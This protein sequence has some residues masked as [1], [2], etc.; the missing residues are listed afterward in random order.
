M[1]ERDP[2]PAGRF[3]VRQAGAVDPAPG[4]L[5]TDLSAMAADGELM[6]MARRPFK[7]R[8]LFSN[9]YLENQLKA[10]PEWARSDHE[11]AFGDIRRIYER[12]SAFVGGLSEAQLEER[13]IRRVFAVILPEYEV[14]GATRSR[15]FPDYAFFPHREARDRA[16]AKKDTESFFLEAF[17][18][19]EVKRWDAELDRFGRDRQDKRRNPSFQIWLYLTE[20]EPAWGILS[21][22]GRWRLYR[23]DRPL[24]VYYE[25][26]L[27][28]ILEA[29]DVD[30]FRYFYYFF[31]QEAFLP[32]QRG[33]VFLE[34][35]LRG[36]A[37]Y[38]REIGENLKENVYR[39]GKVLADGFIRWPENRLDPADPETRGRVQRSTMILLYRFLFLLYAEGKE[40]LDLRDERYASSYSFDRIKKEVAL[41]RDGPAA[42]GFLPIKRSLWSDLSDLFRLIDRGSERLGIGEL[43]EVPAYN[44]GLFDP[45]RH[46]DL[47]EWTIGDSYLAEAI[48]LLSR[49]EAGSG[50]GT[51]TGSG[52]G[53]GGGGGKKGEDGGA[54]G[55][56]SGA[57]GGGKGFVDYSTLEI[58]HLGS[59]Y[60]GLLEY[61]LAVADEDLVVS[62]GKDRRWVSLAEYNQGKKKER[63]FQEF[64]EF[65]RARAGEL[66]LTTDRGERKATG[67]YY[68]P[69]YIVDYIVEKTV[70]P[71]VEGRWKEALLEEQSLIEATLAVKVLDP[72]MGSGHFLVGAVEFLAGKLLRA[73]ERDIDWGWVED[74]GQFTPEW[75]KRE[76]V[77]RCIYGVDLNELAV[78]LA[79]VSLWLSTIAK[80]KPLSFLDHRLKQG[81]SLVG[82]RLSDLMNYPGSVGADKDQTTLPSFVSPRFLTHLIGK[83]REL[84]EIGDD[85]LSEIKEK[86]RVFEEFRSL[87]EYTK[88][89]AIANV[90]T[91]V[92]FGGG[93]EARATPQGTKDP[94]QVYHDLFWAVGGDEGEWRRKTSPRWFSEAQRIAG[95]RSFFHWEL[96]FPEVFFAGGAV[97]DN[98]G[99]DAVVGN[100]P[101]V[102]QEG[103]GEFKGYFGERYRA[104]HGVADLYV[105]F[106][107]LGASLL[108]KEGFFSYILA[109]K[110]MRANYGEPLRR[111]MKER[112]I[113]EIVD[114]GDLPVFPEATTYPCILRLCGGP[115]R[116]SFRAAEVQSLD[117]GSLKG[118]VEERAYSVSLSGL[119]D[120]GWS[121]V[122]E[123]VQRL[124]EKLRRAGTPL[125]EYVNG[126]IFYGI[127]TGLNEAFVIDGETRARLIAEDPKSSELIKPFL[128]GRDIKRYEPPES[129]RYLILVPNGWTRAQSSGSEDPWGWF[130]AK[131]PAVAAHLAQFSEAAQKRYDKGDYWWELRACD[132]YDQFEKP[133]IMYLVFQVNPAFTYDDAGT[134]GNNAIWITPG[135]DLYLLSILNSKL[136]WLLI[137]N[138]CTEIQNGYQL[139][140]KY[141]GKIPIRRIS[142]STP[143]D[144]RRRQLEEL[145]AFCAAGHLDKVLDVVDGCLPGDAA[146]EPIAG[147]ERS[148]VVHDLLAHLAEE[149]IRMNRE[150]QEEIRGFLA[151]LSDFTGARVD[152]LSNKT[153]V[154][155]YYEIEFSELLGV[156]KKNKR[157]LAVDPGRRA[158]GEDLRREYSASVEKLAPLLLR[159]GE[160]DRLIDLIVYRLYGLTAEEAEIV[161]G[162]L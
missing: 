145:K 51:G 43:I 150:K 113:D 131:Y 108:Q 95:E 35:V 162:S 26:N 18:I 74:R 121:L 83:I 119:D 61:S 139:I 94:D 69:D 110:W 70:G 77:A 49:S 79:K 37:N 31:R 12:E 126:K 116:P 132:Y 122:D 20:T 90:H 157:K 71:V 50:S 8:N 114:F 91:A 82:A 128:A 36:S 58:R 60:E 138:Y 148:D 59:I 21:N 154:Q 123:S 32:N 159:I 99:W 62:G 40:L 54:G 98:P 112:C 66:Y 155:A 19:G 109:N 160:V 96:E 100:P 85:S 29:G 56:G 111:W 149:M 146:G 97:K 143:E 102:R 65:D 152:D 75:A 1:L 63:S 23:Q 103:L 141:L 6:P 115:A 88:A 55:D 42:Q 84:E 161:E 101:Y 27:A 68:T 124:L 89:R 67:S 39:A 73:A 129:D 7:N 33:E 130:E 106:V 142:F 48:D 14:Q 80:D 151:W 17:A 156:L 120:S 140:F 134:Y 86:E 5:S 38:A 46:P 11:A 4:P 15:E 41:R 9:H 76:V 117:F 87:P 30:A 57:G 47:A 144:D 10:S 137:S 44:G 3:R 153:K 158:F 25:V 53:R 16:Q 28:A 45:G 78:E 64:S 81:N 92:Y 22:G 72:A 125:G 93:A 133:K 136:G 2:S 13:L 105:Y 127:K 147:S 107:E 118:Y 104:Y 24:D 52:G 34:E 135:E